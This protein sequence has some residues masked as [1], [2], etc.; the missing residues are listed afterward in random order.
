MKK[1]Y[2][3]E[4]FISHPALGATQFAPSQFDAWHGAGEQTPPPPPSV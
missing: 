3:A 1:E 2:A 4:N